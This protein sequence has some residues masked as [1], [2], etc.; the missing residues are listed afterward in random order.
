MESP[1][2]LSEKIAHGR[3]LGSSDFPLGRSLITLGNSLGQLFQTTPMDFQLFVPDSESPQKGISEPVK[4]KWVEKYNS[5]F[6]FNFKCNNKIQHTGDT[7]S[8]DRCR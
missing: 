2:G 5:Y 3:S 4:I 1:L 8:L 6:I 7:E